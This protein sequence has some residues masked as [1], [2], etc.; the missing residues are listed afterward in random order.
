MT[1]EIALT[2]NELGLR[3]SLDG[4]EWFNWDG[5]ITNVAVLD[6]PPPTGG[7]RRLAHRVRS[8]AALLP[9]RP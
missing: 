6:P 1:D 9:P 2:R 7:L 8:I 4:R 3:L 5:R